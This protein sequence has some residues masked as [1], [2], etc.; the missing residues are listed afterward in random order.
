VLSV[1]S[2]ALTPITGSQPP[3]FLAASAKAVTEYPSTRAAAPD[4]RQLSGT[5]AC[6]SFPWRSRVTESR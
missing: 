2:N 1:P 5:A 3:P 6:I 4:K